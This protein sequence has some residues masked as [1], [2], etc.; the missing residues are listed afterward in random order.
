MGT[1]FHVPLDVRNR[2]TDLAFPRI[3]RHPQFALLL[4]S[5]ENAYPSLFA[6]RTRLFRHVFRFPHFRFARRHQYRGCPALAGA[7]TTR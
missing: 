5:A 2:Q 3:R 4:P 7:F 1:A 6:R